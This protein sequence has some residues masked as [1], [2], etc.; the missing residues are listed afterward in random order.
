[1]KDRF[2]VAAKTLIADIPSSCLSTRSLR[3]EIRYLERFTPSPL[4]HNAKM[5]WHSSPSDC[6][7]D[8]TEI[9]LD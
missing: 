6:H 2:K 7:H 1:M 3:K 5:D 4:R 9:A 8:V